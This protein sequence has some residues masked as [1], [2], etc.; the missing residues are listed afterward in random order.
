MNL[1]Y[2]I[3]SNVS[4][5]C[6]T[7]RAWS[8]KDARHEYSVQ[9]F[10]KSDVSLFNWVKKSKTH[11]LPHERNHWPLTN[12]SRLLPWRGNWTSL[13][14][15]KLKWVPLDLPNLNRVWNNYKYSKKSFV[16]ETFIM[17]QYCF[18]QSKAGKKLGFIAWLKWFGTAVWM[19]RWSKTSSDK[20][21]PVL[22][23]PERKR[24][25]L[26]EDWPVSP[27]SGG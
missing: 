13:E 4:C 8:D 24:A 26:G 27:R 17:S 2:R 19:Q 6:P 14:Y 3:T 7:P 9:P 16:S 1:L 21:P 15:T 23:A 5:P 25:Y 18:L 20:L 10:H 11:S 12:Y 22:R